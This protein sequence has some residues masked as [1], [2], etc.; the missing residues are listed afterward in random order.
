MSGERNKNAALVKAQSAQSLYQRVRIPLDVGLKRG[1]NPESVWDM[2]F[3]GLWVYDVSSPTVQV[4]VRFNSRHDTGADIPLKKNMVINHDEQVI[5]CAFTAPPQLG[6]WIEFIFAIDSKLN[7]GNIE[8]QVVGEVGL[9][10]D[11]IEKARERRIIFG[12]YDFPDDGNY[13]RLA[14]IGFG[15]VAGNIGTIGERH[16]S[17]RSLICINRPEFNNSLLT[18]GRFF[19]PPG[20]ELEILGV[21]LLVA[22][23]ADVGTSSLFVGGLKEVA[24]VSRN[25]ISWASQTFADA[26]DDDFEDFWNARHNMHY[27]LSSISVQDSKVRYIDDAFGPQGLTQFKPEGGKAIIDEGQRVALGLATYAFSPGAGTYTVLFDVEV[28]ARLRLKI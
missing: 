9:S 3:K 23:E 8:Q 19:V 5:N 1:R 10:P 13:I 2:P 16:F 17:W 20:H 21:K 25:N 15:N 6:Q 4:S 14:T 18:G 22:T 7:I 28:L 12:N 27:Y 11:A 26:L 24:P